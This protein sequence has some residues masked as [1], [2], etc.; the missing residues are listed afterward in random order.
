MKRYAL[1]NDTAPYRHIGCDAVMQTLRTAARERG[2]EEI[3]THPVGAPLTAERSEALLRDAELVV[4]NGEGTLHDDVPRCRELAQFT[5]LACARGRRVAV[6][7]ASYVGNSPATTALFAR[8]DI[9]AFRDGPSARHFADAR[10]TT[11]VGDLSLQSF[12]SLARP[13]RPERIVFT[14]SVVP[15]QNRRIAQA[16]LRLG[17]EYAPVKDYLTPLKNRT[18]RHALAGWLGSGPAGPGAWRTVAT[19]LTRTRRLR[20]A[21][22]LQDAGLVLTG[23]YH[24]VAFCLH[25]RIPFFYVASNTAKIE[26][27]LSDAGID[28]PA[29]EFAALDALLAAGAAPAEVIGHARF[30]EAE[31]AAI[32]GFLAAQRSKAEALM[33][34]VFA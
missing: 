1:V 7:N 24:A 31:R 11:V 30:S 21:R 28:A 6:V 9:V 34:R 16:A 22:H 5:A 3:A 2:Y 10:H 12:P 4:V 27:L 33:D 26:W 20:F 25:N 32:A 15:P 13:A 18:L 17:A 19:A 29:R 8:A 14:D 23:R